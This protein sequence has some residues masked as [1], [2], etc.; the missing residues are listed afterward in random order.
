MA[1]FGLQLN[2][3]K[4]KPILQEWEKLIWD[5]RHVS[6]YLEDGYD[7]VEIQLQVKNGF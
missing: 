3:S 4:G 7:V 5:V 1:E 6:V 2:F